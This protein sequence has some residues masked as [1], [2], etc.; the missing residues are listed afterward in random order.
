MLRIL[1]K[2]LKLLY[3]ILPS[4]VDR[5]FEIAFSSDSPIK[6]RSGM[7]EKTADDKISSTIS[8]YSIEQDCADKT[9]NICFKLVLIFRD[10][11]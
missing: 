6:L 9:P 7:F 11:F 1:F 4:K 2:L 5:T 10:S 3:E 8:T